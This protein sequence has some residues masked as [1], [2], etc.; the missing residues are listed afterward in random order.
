MKKFKREDT[1]ETPLQK[2]PLSL[3]I[4]P[5]LILLPSMIV[6]LGILY[7]FATAIYYSFTNISF[8]S[9]TYKFIGFTNWVNMIKN[10]DFW[11][12]V[13]NTFLKFDP[14]LENYI[15][16]LTTGNYVKAFLDNLVISG[17]AVIVSVIVGVP[18]AYALAR[19]KFK[20]KEDVAFTILSFKFA[21]EIL[22]II[23]LYKIFMTLHL[24]D[25]YLG[26]GQFN[27]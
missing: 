17:G 13:F 3:R 5:Y 6:L 9:T 23:P 19:Y 22:F 27:Q 25:T 1:A 2:K 20:K 14:T 11:H 7:P 21:P 10:P 15:A 24:Y 26:M 18:A 12:Q 4:R 16:V 8:R